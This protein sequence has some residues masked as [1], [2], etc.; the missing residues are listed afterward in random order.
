VHA[1]DPLARRFGA[2]MFDWDGTA[3]TDR[4]AEV[5]RLRGL[6]ED[7]SARGVHLVVTSGTHLEN[8]RDQLAAHVTGPGRLLIDANRGSET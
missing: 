8:V 7:L 3:V 5:A 6:V 4:R 2:I 1:A